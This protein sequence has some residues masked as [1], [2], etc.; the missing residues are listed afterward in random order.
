MKENKITF[1]YISSKIDGGEKWNKIFEKKTTQVFK[2]DLICKSCK[3][4]HYKTDREK[5]FEIETFITKLTMTIFN[6]SS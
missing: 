1:F 2:I 4:Q 3:T 6:W 5:I